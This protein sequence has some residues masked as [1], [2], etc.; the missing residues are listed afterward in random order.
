MGSRRQRTGPGRRCRC[1]LDARPLRSGHPGIRLRRGCAA[2][3]PACRRRLPRG[4]AWFRRLLSVRYRGD[5]YLLE[6]NP[7]PGKALTRDQGPKPPAHNKWH[8]GLRSQAPRGSLLLSIGSL[9]STIGS[10]SRTIEG[11]SLTRG[12]R[13]SLTT[14]PPL[15]AAGCLSLTRD[16]LMIAG[17]GHRLRNR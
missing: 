5:R 4:R 10:L 17:R 14:D 12:S 15:L 7:R 3:T 2:R 13:L 16:S 11:L 6:P 1:R 9:L 8:Q